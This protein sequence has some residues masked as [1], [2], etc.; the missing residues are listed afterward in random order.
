MLDDLFEKA[1]KSQSNSVVK[2]GCSLTSI[3]Q[4]IE[5]M[6]TNHKIQ[7]RLLVEVLIITFKT[8]NNENINY[9]N[10]NGRQ[11]GLHS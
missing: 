1:I 6:T 3:V 4:W 8:K 11:I 2:R 10:S 5:C 7:V 9:F